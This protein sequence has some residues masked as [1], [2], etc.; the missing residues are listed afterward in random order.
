MGAGPPD[1]RRPHVGLRGTALRRAPRQRQRQVVLRRRGRGN[2]LARGRGLALSEEQRQEPGA[3]GGHHGRTIGEPSRPVK[4][5]G[6]GTAAESG[7]NPGR[8]LIGDRSTASN[9][10]ELTD[11]TCEIVSSSQSALGSPWTYQF[12]PPSAMYMP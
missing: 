10:E 9:T 3:S 1:H 5:Y 11:W 8:D 7:E 12:E 2:G 4:P 6:A